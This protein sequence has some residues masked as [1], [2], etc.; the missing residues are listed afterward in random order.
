M[1]S[2]FGLCLVAKESAAGGCP[3]VRRLALWLGNLVFR[4]RNL[5]FQL[6]ILS[7]CTGFVPRS[8]WDSPRLDLWVDG[9]GLALAFIGQGVRALVSGYVDIGRSGRNNQVYA[10]RLI[11]EG[12]FQ[13]AR[14]PLYLGNLL[15]VSGLFVIHNS[16]WACAVGIPFFVLTYAAMVTAEEGYL[17]SHFGAEYEEYCRRVNRWWPNLRHLGRSVHGMRFSWRRVIRQEH[18]SAYAW[19]VTALL[20]LA[21][22]I[23]TFA[24]HDRWRLFLAVSGAVW[25]ALTVTWAA[26]RI[27]VSRGGLKE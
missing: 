15:I 13:L 3:A 26:A 14:N 5:L 22:D 9:L 20:L 10:K 6:V 17:Q 7:L 27:L 12:P 1:P 19:C 24:P 23:L 2:A 4:Y 8:P 18:G 21:S 11:T 25:V 16:G